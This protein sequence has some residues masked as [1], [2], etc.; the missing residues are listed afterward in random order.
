MFPRVVRVKAVLL[1]PDAVVYRYRRHDCSITG[2]HKGYQQQCAQEIRRE[3]QA[4]YLRSAASAET[5]ANLS[6]FWTLEGGG[7]GLG[8]QPTSGQSIL[9]HI[10]AGMS[11]REIE[12][13][14]RLRRL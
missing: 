3:Y 7:R 11:T 12:P 1:S 10:A 5:D 14:V 2:R 4:Q 6:R 9:Q 13:F 8:R